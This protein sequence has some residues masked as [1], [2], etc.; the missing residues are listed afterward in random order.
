MLTIKFS[1]ILTKALTEKKPS[2]V[3]WIPKCLLK[4]NE[5]KY[6]AS[7][8]EAMD[9]GYIPTIETF[10]EMHRFLP[11]ESEIPLDVMYEMFTT[12]R[13]DEYIAAQT[14]ELIEKNQNDGKSPYEGMATAQQAWLEKTTIISPEVVNYGKLNRETYL[15]NVYRSSFHIPFF[16]EM[17][18]GLQGGD[19]IVFMAPT[20][21]YKTTLLKLAAQRAF[22]K[23]ENVLI[24][25]QEQSVTSLAQQLDMQALEKSHSRLRA[26][27]DET[28]LQELKT[29]EQKYKKYQNNL[30]IIPQIRSVA[31]LHGYLVSFNSTDEKD[32]V[33]KVF[34]DGLNL[35]Q[36]DSADSFTSLQ[37][38]C[39]DLKSYAIKNNI[40]IIVVT[41]TNRDGY[42]SNTSVGAQHIAGSF[43][44]AQYS[45]ILIALT[46]ITENG[47][48][49]VYIRPILNRHGDL[50]TKISMHV[51]YTKDGKFSLSF[52]PLDPEW[53][54]DQPF[55]SYTAAKELKMKL[56]E[57]LGL[58]FSE[59]SST[60]GEDAANAL[61]NL[62][63]QEGAF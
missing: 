11:M 38:V 24:A 29:L 1:Q 12:Q 47:E 31:E 19:F 32:K 8:Q 16:D 6:V 20:K 22:F 54:P 13:R 60:L 56:K 55:I 3:T 30:W 51:S 14:K 50:K 53:E 4:D 45:D 41:Q 21:S 33:R 61:L 25:S 46:P 36:G 7:L 23:K 58:E 44:I 39:A 10:K 17:S 9:K 48:I 37:K 40:I 34:I 63:L 26:G 27:I 42:K 49:Y 35:M 52:A 18:Q 28:Q 2:H 15:S 57:E 43:A 5:L 62:S 59:I